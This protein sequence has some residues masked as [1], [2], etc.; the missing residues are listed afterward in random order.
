ME[1]E[2]GLWANYKLTSNTSDL[3]RL[4]SNRNI[5][6]LRSCRFLW[7]LKWREHGLS[8]PI[9]SLSK[10]EQTMTTY[11]NTRR[12]QQPYRISKE[13]VGPLVDKV[14]TAEN[15]IR[16]LSFCQNEDMKDTNTCFQK[17]DRWRYTWYHPYTSKGA[18]LDLILASNSQ[19]IRVS[20]RA[21]SIAATDS[22][23]QSLR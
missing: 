13:Y 3:N 18:M 15:G 2:N 19:N 23:Q 16:L 1:S 10:G 6:L 9:Q 8:I 22:W 14:S 5:R 7:G 20:R 12:H 17:P 4:H 21:D 11:H